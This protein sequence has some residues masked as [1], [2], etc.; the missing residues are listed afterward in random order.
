M[1]ESAVPTTEQEPPLPRF[2]ALGYANYR[3]FW[4]ANVARVFGLQFRF[5]GAGWLTHLLTPSPVWLGIVGLAAAIPTIVLSVPAGTLA[6]RFDNRKLLVWSQALTALCMFAMAFL[7]V[8]ELATVAIVVIW[9]VIV[10][11]LLALGTPAQ[12]AILPRLIEMRATA[13]AVAYMSAI[14]NVM[15]IVGPAG[16]GL[17]ISIIG[18]GQAFTVTGLAFAVSVVLLM[19]LRLEPIAARTTQSGGGMLEGFRFVFGNRLFFATIGL[20]FFTSLFG[21]SYVV[22][23]PAFTVILHTDARGFGWMEAAAGLG[24]LLGTVAIV[25]LRQGIPQG[26]VMLV[27]AALFGVLIALFTAATTLPIAMLF[28]FLGGVASSLY[29]NL[30]MTALQLQVPNA[31]RGRVMGIWSMT[32]FLAAAGGLPAAMVATWIGTPAAVALGALSVTAFAI[33]LL[34]FVPSLRA[35]GSMDAPLVTAARGSS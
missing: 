22:L 13:S 21:M 3:Q 5:I 23:L 34:V 19:R 4:L 16:A 1:S 28:L 30:G 29:L 27:S 33:L 14:W 7:V 35:P 11:A 24:S 8:A 26:P 9:S 2:G 25:R 12:N 20:S 32:Y 31:L 17:L 10:G 6:D 15:R 18:P